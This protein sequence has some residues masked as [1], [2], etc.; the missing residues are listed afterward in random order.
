MCI[1]SINVQCSFKEK[2]F[3]LLSKST[4]QPFLLTRILL[5]QEAVTI[6]Q[7][8]TKRHVNSPQM[9]SFHKKL[10]SFVTS[11][12]ETIEHIKYNKDK[13]NTLKQYQDSLINKITGKYHNE[14][15]TK[16][17]KTFFEL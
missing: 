11:T 7:Y 12:Y 5:K 4:A 15:I 8:N 6:N 17:N 14:S 10:Y 16:L 3:L 9:I 2:Q 13:Y 1:T